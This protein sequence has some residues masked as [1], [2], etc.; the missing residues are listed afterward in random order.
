MCFSLVEQTPIGVISLGIQISNGFQLF[1]IISI[2]FNRIDFELFKE[3]KKHLVINRFIFNLLICISC[4]IATGI[5]SLYHLLELFLQFF[6]CR[7]NKRTAI[8][9]MTSSHI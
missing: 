6:F 4:V 8:I 3:I 2:F 1:L 5:L 9:K 7:R